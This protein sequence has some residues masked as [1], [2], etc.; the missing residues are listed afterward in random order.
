MAQNGR[1]RYMSVGIQDFVNFTGIVIKSEPIGEYDRRVV[2]LTKERGKISAFARGARRAG[3]RLMAPTN[4]FSFGQFRLFAGKTSYNLSEAE[5]SNY[6]EELREDFVGAYYGMYFLEIC[7]Y[8]T[9]ENNDETQVLKLLYQ[10]LRAL[11]SKRFENRLV[12]CIFE[13]KAIMLN[14]EFPAL[15]DSDMLGEG[16]VYTITYIMNTPSEKLFS[17]TVKPYVLQELEHFCR[18]ICKRTFDKD[19]KSLEI[20]ENLE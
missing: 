13:L 17:F 12:R 4:P 14:G 16:T 1:E 2:L 9:R 6:F 5:I 8:Y 7:D 10:S 19:F 20:L 3:N 11:A 18:K 15:Q